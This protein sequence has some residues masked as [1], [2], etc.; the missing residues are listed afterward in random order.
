MPSVVPIPLAT[1]TRPPAS[2]AAESA[3]P[4]MIIVLFTGT[5]TAR[6]TPTNQGAGGFL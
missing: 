1:L 5:K 6:P 4:R 2:D 3:I